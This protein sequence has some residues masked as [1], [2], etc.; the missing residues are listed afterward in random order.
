[1]ISAL[2]G[3]GVKLSSCA[4]YKIFTFSK[5]LHYLAEISLSL[6]SSSAKPP[7]IHFSGLTG[8]YF[9]FLEHSKFSLTS[10]TWYMSTLL[11]VHFFPLFEP[12]FFFSY[13]LDFRINVIYSQKSWLT[14]PPLL[15][16]LLST[17]AQCLFL[18]RNF[19]PATN[20]RTSEKTFVLSTAVIYR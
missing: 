8:F 7:L 4:W 15:Y 12:L 20:C 13:L 10:R 19:H 1:M 11:G 14:A 16:P 18:S 9:Q 5:T 17:Q 3:I 2:L 6:T